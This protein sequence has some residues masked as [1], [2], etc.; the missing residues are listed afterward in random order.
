LPRRCDLFTAGLVA[1]GLLFTSSPAAAQPGSRAAQLPA[2]QQQAV[3]PP[4][5]ALTVARLVWSSL[6]ALDHANQTGNYSVLRDLGAPSFQVNN[7]AATLA[8]IFERIRTAQIDL[9]YAFNVNRFGIFP[10]LY[11]RPGCFASAVLSRSGRRRSC[12]TCCSRT[13][14]D[15]GD[16]SVSR[17]PRLPLPI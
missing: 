10:P 4:V 3:Q 12:S 8:G 1:A 14:T 13:S 17:L 7:S 9:S 6:A 5:D 16:C 15:S 11:S 2:A